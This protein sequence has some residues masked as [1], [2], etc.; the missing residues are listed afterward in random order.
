MARLVDISGK[1]YG[2]LVVVEFS[3]YVGEKPR[4]KA[5]W[6]CRCDCGQEIVAQGLNLHSGH[7]QSC[8]CL[9]REGIGERR[10]THGYSTGGK[11]SPTYTTWN[12]MIQRC[13]NAKV[14][15]YHNY[16]GRGIKVCKRW[17]KF[18][19]FLTDMGP[20]PRGLSI[21]RIDNNGNYEPG[22]CRWATLSQ[23]AS[24]RRPRRK[25][26]DIQEV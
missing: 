10:K 1:R 24:N 23:Q 26:R 8:G 13:T 2:R 12:N 25:A 3:H 16:G 21:D 9:Q 19:N 22:N 7:T 14:G 6:I 5:M 20:K 15:N 18:E 17:D 11:M 4:R